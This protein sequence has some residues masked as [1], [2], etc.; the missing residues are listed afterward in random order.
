MTQNLVNLVIPFTKKTNIINC[1]CT[2]GTSLILRK[3]CAKD[4]GAYIDCKLHFG[5]HTD[6]LFSYAMESLK[7]IRKITFYFS[8]TDSLMMLYLALVCSKLDPLL[9]T[10]LRLLTFTSLN[11]CREN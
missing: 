4:F 3:D 1:L 11:A 6:F 10:L 5:H 8:T 9:G 2:L 7:L